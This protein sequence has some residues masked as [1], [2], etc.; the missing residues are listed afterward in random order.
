MNQ[1]EPLGA[2]VPALSLQNPKR[3]QLLQ[4]LIP[5]ASLALLSPGSIL[6]E[7]ET[8]KRGTSM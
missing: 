3:E 5:R 1:K 4:L 2:Q 6:S 8:K 7:E